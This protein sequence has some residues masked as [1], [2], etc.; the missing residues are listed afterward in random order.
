MGAD[1]SRIR[2][3]PLLDF[4]AVELKQ[5]GVLL[6]AD[7][8]EFSAL[9]DRRFRAAAS[10]ILGR[11][12][13]SSTTPDAFKITPVAGGLEID[14]GRLYVDGLL[15]ENHGAVSSDPAKKLFDPL[16]A[17]VSF[18]DKLSYAAQ[19]YLPSPPALPTTGRHLVYLDVWQR[20]LTHLERTDLVEVAVGV[21][22]SS[23]VQTVWQVRVLEADAGGADCGSPDAAVS[24]W[25]ALIDA[26]TG[27]LTTGTF[28]VSLESDPCELPPTGGYRGLENQTY[29]VEIHDPGQPGGTA[30]F[31]WSREN[32]SVGSRVASMVSASE[33]ELQS[34]GRDDVLRFNSGDW[35]EITDEVREFSQRCGE[36]RKITVNE[37]ARRITFVPALPPEM[38]PAAF[39]DS[40]F[41]DKRNLRVR[42]WDHKHQVLRTDIGGTTA[43]YQD[44]DATTAGVI[45]VPAAGT[46]LLLENGVTVSFASTGTKGFKAGDYWVFAARTSGASVELLENAPPRG[47]HHHYAWLGFWDVA[48]GT[49]SD[50]RNPWPPEGGEGCCTVIVHPGESIQAAIDSLPDAG[51]CVCLKSGTHAITTPIF[52]NR[53]GVTLHGESPGVRVTANAAAGLK[54]MLLV[55]GAEGTVSDVEIAMIRFEVAE[56]SKTA[57][58]V[59]LQACERVRVAQCAMRYTGGTAAAVV[60][61]S[62]LNASDI[63]ISGNFIER[64]F[65]GVDTGDLVSRLVVERNV[66][67]GL[68]RG[69]GANQ[70]PYSQWGVKIAQ[71]ASVQ[72]RQND[73]ED[74]MIG[75]GALA[76]AAQVII[77]DNDIRRGSLSAQFDIPLPPDQMLFAIEA[78]ADHCRIDGN[79]IDLSAQPYGGIRVTG[80]HNEVTGNRLESTRAGA[81]TR[82]PIGVL[83]GAIAQAATGAGDS[84]N[85]AQNHFTGAQIALF[86]SRVLGL[87]VAG[88]T[89]AGQDRQGFGVWLDTCVESSVEQNRVHGVMLP[90]ALSAGDRNR[91]TGNVVSV[92]AAGALL[93]KETALEFSHNLIEDATLYGIGVNDIGRSNRFAHNRLAHCA[94]A[95]AGAAVA[96]GVIGQGAGIDLT[97]ESCDIINTGLSPDRATV[98]PV[99]A[100]GIAAIMVATCEIT[101]NRV[102]YEDGA[103][104]LLDQNLEHRA[105]GLVGMPAYH[106]AVGAGEVQFAQGAALIAGNTFQGPGRTNLVELRRVVA[107]P[108]ID[109]RFEKVTFAN[110]RCD[111]STAAGDQATTVKLFGSHLIVTSNHVKA[112][113]DVRAF[114]LGGRKTGLLGNA[115]T[116]TYVDAGAAIPLPIANFNFQT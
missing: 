104:T 66:L 6:D 92:C 31:K 46:T 40:V 41:P 90:L 62:L 68:V 54:E 37:A 26:S 99:A 108:Q 116:G 2:S 72:C 30:T 102:V 88:N 29:R 96:I 36:V 64:C 89:I 100:A 69:T 109:L 34:L 61:V 94:Y 15:A 93:V 87:K 112:P 50:C 42:R 28:D 79:R 81:V 98:T 13:V 103:E 86:A 113:Q 52:V 73:I 111:H 114:D 101:N 23:R 16:L 1:L 12:T 25:T 47:I 9:V 84:S 3:N 32:A 20:E 82:G 70:V 71:G 76:G 19:P 58:I 38:I 51:G 95:A 75:V 63:E 85:V 77:A 18:A 65:H 53:S 110:N 4:A 17:E 59:L 57:I 21:E 60:G 33:L 105:V 97:I 10:D 106:V 67:R 44:L 115:T 8:N 5:G 14:K 45:K 74:F 80:Q 49:V 7:F 35:V 24:G 39:P 83:V 55:G 56:V 11:S 107:S 48:A 22:T 43:L 78:Q 27:R 91:V